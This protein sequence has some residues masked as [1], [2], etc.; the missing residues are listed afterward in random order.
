MLLHYFDNPETCSLFH[1]YLNNQLL[2]TFSLILSAISNAPKRLLIIPSYH[3]QL[4]QFRIRVTDQVQ[5]TPL[6]TPHSSKLLLHQKLVDFHYHYHSSEIENLPNYTPSAPSNTST[7]VLSTTRLGDTWL[8]NLKKL[9]TFLVAFG[10]LDASVTTRLN[11]LS[12]HLKLHQ[13]L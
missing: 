8:E 11:L 7:A 4:A 1:I 2:E 5:N 9:G 13:T 3:C 12:E 6:L 10:T